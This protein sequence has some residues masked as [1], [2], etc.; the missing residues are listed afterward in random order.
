MRYLA[1]GYAI[2]VDF[3]PANSL[4][5]GAHKSIYWKV[6]NAVTA[7]VIDPNRLFSG[8]RDEE[9]H[10]AKDGIIFEES[11][12]DAGLFPVLSG[13]DRGAEFV[14]YFTG[15][16]ICDKADFKLGT[17]CGSRNSRGF[18][19]IAGLAIDGKGVGHDH[20]VF[21]GLSDAQRIGAFQHTCGIARDGFF[22]FAGRIYQ[23]PA[24]G[25]PLFLSGAQLKAGVEHQIWLVRSL[26]LQK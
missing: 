1:D 19:E 14:T 13:S 18:D 8:G 5:K 9:N 12:T 10:S 16:V 3:R 15:I 6:V 25:H 23:N 22:Q 2:D 20:L 4:D 11:G 17:T 26:G 24:A 7:N 21:I